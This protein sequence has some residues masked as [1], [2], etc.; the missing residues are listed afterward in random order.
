[1]N[2]NNHPQLTGYQ[3]DVYD[4]FIMWF[5]YETNSMSR[6]KDE[7]DV[8]PD[9]ISVPVCL[10]RKELRGLPAQM[11]AR[12]DDDYTEIEGRFFVQPLASRQFLGS[13]G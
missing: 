9:S 7:L 10:P 8:V 3:I 6:W 2:F 11:L 1:M 5:L 4:L 12:V 13:F